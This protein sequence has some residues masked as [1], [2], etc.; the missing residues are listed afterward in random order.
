[1]VRDCLEWYE[2]I[3]SSQQWCGVV[4]DCLEWYEMGK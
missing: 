4:R 3:S 2:V 1:M